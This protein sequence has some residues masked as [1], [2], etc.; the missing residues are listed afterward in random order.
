MIYVKNLFLKYPGASQDT[1]NDITFSIKSGE[2]FGFLGPSG[3]GKSTLQKILTGILL[4]YRGEVKVLGNEIRNRRNTFYEN[5]GVDFEFPNFYDKFSALENLNYF[6]SLYNRKVFNPLPLLERVGL[7]EDAN[8]K[9]SEFS[10]GMK[11]RLSFVRSILH[12]PEILF[13]DEPTSGLDPFNSRTIKDIII[14]NRNKGKT[15]I[16]TTHNMHD[17]EELCDRVAFIVDGNL[18]AID[19]PRALR[20]RKS[21]ISVDYSYLENGI[22]YRASSQLTDLSQD[23]VFTNKLNIG[24]ILSIHSKE[25]TLEDIFIE[26]TGRCL[27]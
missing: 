5:I 24:A 14:E 9:V 16:L 26:L 19:T 13:L 23:K 10:K 12:N 15:I 18:R 17:A 21:G 11:M 8:K 25:P 27:Q 22:E 1:I 2:I 7:A 3:A 20:S 6:A 4:N